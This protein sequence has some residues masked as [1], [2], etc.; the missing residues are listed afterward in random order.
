[1]TVAEVNKK[2]VGDGTNTRNPGKSQAII[3]GLPVLSP[4]PPE[5][6]AFQALREWIKASDWRWFVECRPVMRSRI[7]FRA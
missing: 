7:G 4:D 5:L 6:M 3:E 1:M 2:N